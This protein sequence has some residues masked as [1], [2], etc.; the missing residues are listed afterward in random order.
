[1][2]QDDDL[3]SGKST[4]HVQSHS[5]WWLDSRPSCYSKAGALTAKYS[6]SGIT[7]PAIVEKK[8]GG[9]GQANRTCVSFLDR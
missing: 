5:S 8:L 7:S 1:M 9:R 6:M 3:S 2:R 4:F